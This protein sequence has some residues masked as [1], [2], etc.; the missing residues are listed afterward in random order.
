MKKLFFLMLLI[1]SL[2]FADLVPMGTK[3]INFCYKFTNLNDYPDYVFIIH[4]IPSPYYEVIT[5]DE[6]FTFYKFSVVHMYAIDKNMFDENMLNQMDEKELDHYLNNNKHILKSNIPLKSYYKTVPIT[7]N[8]KDITLI[9]SVKLDGNNLYV[10]WHSE[11][12]DFF[13]NL[14]NKIKDIFRKIK[15]YFS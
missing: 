12:T 6:C 3:P 5:N 15:L 9:G 13:S 10:N 14:I 8:E 1:M 4:G 7:S 11:N 2:V